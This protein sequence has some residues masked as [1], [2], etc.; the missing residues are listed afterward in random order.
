MLPVCQTFVLGCGVLYESFFRADLDA[1]LHR[2]NGVKL[3]VKI[4]S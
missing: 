1:V 3:R 4:L 2:Q